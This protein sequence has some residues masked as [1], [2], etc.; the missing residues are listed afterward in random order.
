MNDMAKQPG[1]A[2]ERSSRPL[3]YSRFKGQPILEFLSLA[4]GEG[5]TLSHDIACELG[6]APRSMGGRMMA[7]EQAC[8]VQRVEV[9]PR[10]SFRS[11]A[12]YGWVLTDAGR[13]EVQ[14]HAR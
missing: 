2:A 11:D 6:Y 1:R 4:D 13:D 10:A 7:L 8:L 9:K 14:R 5:C 12:L 3:R